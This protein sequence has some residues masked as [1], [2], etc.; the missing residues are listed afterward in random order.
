MVRRRPESR[1]R[2][3]KTTSSS[4]GERTCFQSTRV[5]VNVRLATGVLDFVTNWAEQCLQ[6]LRFALRSFARARAFSIAAIATLAIGIGANTA[7]FSVVSGVLL[8]PLPFADSR[9][10][11]QLSEIQPRSA[12]GVGFEGG[13][14]AQDLAQWKATSRS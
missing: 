9:N 14:V 6:D 13:V 10:L 1:W 4:S 7:I 12:A 11:V 5:T 8:R 3:S 2:R